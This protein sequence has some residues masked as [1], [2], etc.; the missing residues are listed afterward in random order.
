M[1]QRIFARRTNSCSA[2]SELRVDSQKS[3]GSLA[4]GGERDDLPQLSGSH[5]HF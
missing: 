1:R 3:V 4:P 2:V 5:P